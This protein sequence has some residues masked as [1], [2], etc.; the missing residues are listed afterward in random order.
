MIKRHASNSNHHT[1]MA[2]TDRSQGLTPPAHVEQRRKQYGFNELQE[3]RRVTIMEMFWGQFKEF[4]VL[5]LI[6][7]G[8]VSLAIGE[9]TDAWSS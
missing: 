1:E 7:A 3:Q 6:A 4:L 8:V 9:V 2:E 5:L